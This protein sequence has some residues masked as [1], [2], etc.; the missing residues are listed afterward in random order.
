MTA[1]VAWPGNEDLADR[2]AAALGC[3]LLEL[4]TRRFPDGETYVRVRSGCRGMRVAVVASLDRPDEKT[5]GLLFL[6]DALR[7]AGAA[8][9]GLVAPYLAYLRQDVQFHPGEAVSSRTYA[10]LLSSGFDWLVTVDPHLHRYGSLSEIYTIPT[11]VVHAAPAIAGWISKHVK[12]PALIGPDA[13][14]EQW[15]TDIAG[16]CNAPWLVLEK[17]RLGDTN[18]KVSVPDPAQLRNRTPVLV[19]D[20]L[21]SG[22]T[23]I[24]AGGQLRELGISGITCIGVHPILGGDALAA[25]KGAGIQQVVSCNTIRHA[26]NEIDLSPLLKEAVTRFLEQP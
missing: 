24:A 23:M 14:S 15:I 4:E 10:R 7:A 12:A 5:P 6:A 21:S 25:M 3:N 26:T 1:I 11:K 8:K 22:R 17:K 2:L 20:I 18:V 16:R 9:V 13:E 19:D